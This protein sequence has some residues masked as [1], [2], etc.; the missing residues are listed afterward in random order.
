MKTKQNS[1]FSHHMDRRHFMAG[2]LGVTMSAA[3]GSIAAAA[4]RGTAAVARRVDF[5]HHCIPPRHLAAILAQ[6][7]SGRPPPRRP[8]MP[9]EEVDKYGTAPSIAYLRERGV[10]IGWNGNRRRLALGRQR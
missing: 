8:E 3:A 10:R 1:I 9:I 5:H 2:A 4:Q 6:R 7:E